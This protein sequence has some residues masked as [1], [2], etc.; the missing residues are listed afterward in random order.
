MLRKKR[1]KYCL[2]HGKMDCHFLNLFNGLYCASKLGFVIIRKFVDIC[3][4]RS[5]N[6][7][8]LECCASHAHCY[9]KQDGLGLSP[10]AP[11]SFLDS[12]NEPNRV[13]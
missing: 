8:K 9:V 11:C 10:P 1:D 2:S 5:T 12:A 7:D 3:I 6:V 13:H 4:K